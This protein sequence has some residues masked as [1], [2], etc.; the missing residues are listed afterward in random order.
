MQF[1]APV[2]CKPMSKQDISKRYG[3]LSEAAERLDT[4][5]MGEWNVGAM[6]EWHEWATNALQ[7]VSVSFGE[8]SI[9]FQN[10]K[11][12]IE[13]DEKMGPEHAAFTARGAFRAARENFDS[14][15][16]TTLEQNLSG[17]ILGDLLILADSAL[18]QDTKESAAVLA[19]AAF[20]D[21]LKKIGTLNNLDLADKELSEVVNALKA[22]QILR[23]GA[24][25][26]AEHFIKLRNFAMHA[27]WDKITPEEVGSL[28]GFVRLVLSEHLS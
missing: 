21:S 5:A 6:E 1:S 28:I 2:G 27:N 25:K 20:E 19:A 15:F 18:E 24:A 9:P 13:S 12:A 16:A 14:G 17:E 7:I 11:K 3:V 10:L 8:K 26:T 4:R 22:K 23:G